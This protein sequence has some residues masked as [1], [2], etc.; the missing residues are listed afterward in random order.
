MGELTGRMCVDWMV[1][2]LKCEGGNLDLILPAIGAMGGFW[3]GTMNSV[4]SSE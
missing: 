2:G 1:E 3:S 4:R